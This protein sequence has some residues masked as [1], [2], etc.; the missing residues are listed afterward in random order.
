MIEKRNQSQRYIKPDEG[1][2]YPSRFDFSSDELLDLDQRRDSAYSVKTL[3]LSAQPI[4]PKTGLTAPFYEWV[5]SGR[6][7]A[8]YFYA[9]SDPLKTPIGGLINVATQQYNNDKFP[10]KNGRGVRCDFTRLYLSWD[11]QTTVD[12]DDN[13]VSVMCD[14]IIFNYNAT[15][16][17]G[18]I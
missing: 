3:D 18:A 2:E 6:T 15:P 8:A 16:Y 4:D 14:F 13:T 9:A 1:A 12:P 17:S 7:Y 11:N 10:V 5:K